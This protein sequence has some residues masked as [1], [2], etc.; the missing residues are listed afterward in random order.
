M[1]GRR[2]E[3]TDLGE[4]FIIILTV[5]GAKCCNFV[6][7]APIQLPAHI[8]FCII[9]KSD[10]LLKQLGLTP[11]NSGILLIFELDIFNACL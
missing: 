4:I 7:L 8:I 6:F 10:T 9:A 5:L 3:I 2:T 11:R 1:E